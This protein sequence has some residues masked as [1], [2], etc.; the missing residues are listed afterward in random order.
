MVQASHESSLQDEGD[1]NGKHWGGE[2][3]KC[4]RDGGM[5]SACQFAPCI[6]TQSGVAGLPT[7]TRPGPA[8]HQN[9][10]DVSMELLAVLSFA[11]HCHNTHSGVSRQAV[12]NHTQSNTLSILQYAQAAPLLLAFN[13]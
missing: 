5:V 1:G 7:K 4:T 6:T 13:G 2:H 10:P 8:Q 9:L 12:N 3:Q 11:Q